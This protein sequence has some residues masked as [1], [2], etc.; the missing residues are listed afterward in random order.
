M[1][2]KAYELYHVSHVH[3]QINTSSREKNESS[4]GSMLFTGEVLI[5]K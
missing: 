2:G 5:V 1:W 4:H 3:T